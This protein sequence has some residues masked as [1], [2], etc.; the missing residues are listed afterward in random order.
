MFFT[1]GDP[2]PPDAGGTRRFSGGPQGLSRHQVSSPIPL[3]WQRTGLS[4]HLQILPSL[5]SKEG[6]GSR[7]PLLT[8]S[9]SGTVQSWIPLRQPAALPVPARAEADWHTAFI[10]RPL[11]SPEP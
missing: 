10:S 6:H 2:T 11:V 4:E 3:L 5:F 7:T 1:Q 9:L 8:W